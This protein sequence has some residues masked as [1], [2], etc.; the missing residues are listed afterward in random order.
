MQFS[1]LFVKNGCTQT[2]SRF[3]DDDCELGHWK[4]WA[5][6]WRKNI[7]LWKSEINPKLLQNNALQH[8]L[9]RLNTFK[10][11]SKNKNMKFSRPWFW[12]KTIAW[13]FPGHDFRHLICLW[14]FPDHACGWKTKKNIPRTMPVLEHLTVKNIKSDQLIDFINES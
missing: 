8:F 14:M 9:T 3:M 10:I 6:S 5:D 1:P 2:A 12:M 4:L 7:K 13:N 11:L